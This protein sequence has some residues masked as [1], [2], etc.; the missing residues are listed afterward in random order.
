MANEKNDDMSGFL[1]SQNQI[2]GAL[3]EIWDFLNP[4]EKIYLKEI[5]DTENA[6]LNNVNLVSNKEITIPL[7]ADFIKEAIIEKATKITFDEAT[8]EILKGNEPITNILSP[9]EFRLL[10]FL[11]L[12]QDKVSEKEEVIESVWKNAKTQEGVTDQALDQIIYRLRKKI[13][14][15]PNNPTH[16]QTVKGRGFRFS[17]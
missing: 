5:P 7:L 9:S 6:Y 10:K 3:T 8:N 17:E 13:E 16:I 11:I 15:D 4:S 2:K 1:S 12:N 14:E